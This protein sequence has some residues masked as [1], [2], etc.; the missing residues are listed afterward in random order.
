MSAFPPPAAN[1]TATVDSP[2]RPPSS[3]SA[4]P[5]TPNVPLLPEVTVRLGDLVPR[6]YR[7][8]FSG[9]PERRPYTRRRYDFPGNL[10]FL[11][12][13]RAFLSTCAADRPSDFRDL[14]TLLGSE[15]AA[16]AIAHTYSGRPGGAFTLITRRSVD[17]L[18]LLCCDEGT[19]I[20]ARGRRVSGASV[21]IEG[22]A[23]S[24]PERSPLQPGRL[25]SDA[26]SS[27]GLA[28]VDALATSW[29]DN[30]D[31]YYRKVWFRLD[32]DLTANAW[33]RL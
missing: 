9:R 10:G 23:A 33:N 25:V 31:P 15:L 1:T 26:D 20:P 13:V 12:L 4:A 28:L 11:P 7:H 19:A 2:A 24:V 3:D 16:N 14:F 5:H 8:Y 21:G 27:R 30:G 32:F 29:G 6:Q 18:T 17:A 22:D